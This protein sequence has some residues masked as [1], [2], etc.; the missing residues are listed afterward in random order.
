MPE[1]RLAAMS[2]RGWMWLG[3][4]SLI[5]GSGFLLTTIA[6]R[7]MPPATSILIRL[8]LATA[9]LAPLL[10]RRRLAL[11]RG[12]RGWTPFLVLGL[13]NTTLPFTLNA[14]SLTRIDS[15]I[16]GILTATVPIFTVIVAHLATRDERATGAKVTGIGLGMAGVVL[17]LGMDA[18]ALTS[19]STAGKLAVLLASVLYGMGAVYARSL[20]GIPPLMLAFGQIVTSVLYLTPFVLVV[21]RP[22]EATTWGA[23]TLAAIVALGVFGSAAAYLI[24]YSL[25]TT[26]GAIAA[27]LVAYLIPLVAV[28][29]GVLFLDE[30]LLGQHVAGMVLILSA[31]ALI[32]GRLV[33]RLANGRRLRPARP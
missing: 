12:L 24:F 2:G 22:W 23:G 29:L 28:V 33:Q 19:G 8:V 21:D 15:G 5:W 7:D 14:W 30:R 27:S 20:Q 17:I 32:D 31:M 26:S 10:R 13:L 25:L 1:T 6:V 18:D 4:L 9:V 11:P 16:A 3:L